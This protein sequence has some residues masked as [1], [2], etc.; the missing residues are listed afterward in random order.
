VP[1]G[2]VRGTIAPTSVIHFLSFTE[3]FDLWI[4]HF[5]GALGGLN[6]FRLCRE[7]EGVAGSS[8]LRGSHREKFAGKRAAGFVLDSQMI[9][10]IRPPRPCRGWLGRVNHAPRNVVSA[11]GLNVRTLEKGRGLRQRNWR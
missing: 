3:D 6:R 10:G 8:G 9:D 4:D 5:R 7:D 1:S 2:F 11:V